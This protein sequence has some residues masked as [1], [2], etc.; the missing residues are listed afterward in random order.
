MVAPQL[1]FGLNFLKILF[2]CFKLYTF[3]RIIL[4]KTQTLKPYSKDVFTVPS[5]LLLNSATS[6]STIAPSFE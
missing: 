4:S 2:L 1:S 5:L 6:G 3:Q